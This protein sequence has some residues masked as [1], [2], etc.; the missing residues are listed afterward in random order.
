MRKAIKIHGGQRYMA[1][2][3]IEKMPPHVHYVEPFFG[4]GEV[5][6]R[7][8]PEGI[9][10]VVNDID[11]DL[12][13]FWRVLQGQNSFQ[14]FTRLCETTPFSEPD[15]NDADLEF[16]ERP[17]PD[18]NV[19]SP[20][21]RAWRFFVHARMSMAG[22]RKSFTPLTRKRV[23][24]A[25]N[26]EASAWLSAIDGL[27]AVHERLKRVVILC[28]DARE[29]IRQQ[30]GPDTLFYLDPPF[31]PETRTAPDVYVHE[32]TPAQHEN[33]LKQILEIKGKVLLSGYRNSLY[34]DLLS[35]WAR[36]DFDVP[37][38]AASGDAKRIMKTS[39]WRNFP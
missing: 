38:H 26:A 19:S 1:A 29:V 36:D 16:T 23:R 33:L 27:P 8:N 25:M 30:D 6:F 37:N 22:R 10:E 3:I 17:E 7:K 18:E 4:A 24:R 11:K 20:P 14:E 5:L 34:D 35:T 39:L 28:K 15:W 12:M 31:Y 13:N 21:V 9:S 2:H 32:M